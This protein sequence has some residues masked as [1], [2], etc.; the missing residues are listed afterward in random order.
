MNHECIGYMNLGI[1]TSVSPP[2]DVV[3]SASNKYNDNWDN[4]AD[5]NKI[6]ATT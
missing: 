5:R 6:I 2:V 4:N 1:L 3:H